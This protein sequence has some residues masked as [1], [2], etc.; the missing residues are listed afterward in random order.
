MFNHLGAQQ[1]IK[2]APPPQLFGNWLVCGTHYIHFGSSVR[3]DV[4]S[5]IGITNLLQYGPERLPTTSNV[6]C[7]RTSPCWRSKA[8]DTGLDLALQQRHDE[9]FL[10][11]IWSV[12]RPLMQHG[13][14]R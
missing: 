11:E 1:K 3:I 9:L 4:N 7:L 5:T 10:W 2:W 14:C 8:L 12:A 13:S 6:D